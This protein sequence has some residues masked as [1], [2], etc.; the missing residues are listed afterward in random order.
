MTLLESPDLIVV[1]ECDVDYGSIMRRTVRTT[2]VHLFTHMKK[3]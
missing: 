2:V 1:A 3:F